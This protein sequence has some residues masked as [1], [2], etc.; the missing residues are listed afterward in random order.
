MMTP[1]EYQEL[2][3]RYSW[4][5]EEAG[6]SYSHYQLQ[7]LADSYMTLRCARASCRAGGR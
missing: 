7:T 5:A 4:L 6:D 1:E 2:A 3:V